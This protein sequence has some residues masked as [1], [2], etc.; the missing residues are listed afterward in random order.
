MPR[1]DEA[2]LANKKALD[3][4]RSEVEGLRDEIRSLAEAFRAG[5]LYPQE[6]RVNPS[7]AAINSGPK[8]LILE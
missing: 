1:A 2:V 7:P 4:L 6:I 5:P 8:I 3:K